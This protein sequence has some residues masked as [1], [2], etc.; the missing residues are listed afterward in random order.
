MID[1]WRAKG[2]KGGKETK[3]PENMFGQLQFRDMY[4][5]AECWVEDFQRIRGNKVCR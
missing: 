2:G 4:A 1:D 5:V 3:E